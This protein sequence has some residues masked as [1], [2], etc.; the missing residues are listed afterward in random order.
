MNT[1]TY[2]VTVDVSA[3]VDGQGYASEVNGPWGRWRQEVSTDDPRGAA[4]ALWETRKARMLKALG[5][6]AVDESATEW[7]DISNLHT[8]HIFADKYHV[9]LTL[10]SAGD[11]EPEGD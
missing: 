10:D 2:K 4:E 9:M 5:N 6:P 3:W 7:R 11:D 1:K 8:L